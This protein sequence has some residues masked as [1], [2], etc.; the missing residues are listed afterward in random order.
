MDTDLQARI[1][2]LYE[3]ESLTDNLTDA[4]AKILLR[5]AEAQLRE[6]TDETLVVAALQ[7]ANQSDATASDALLAQAQTFLT[8]E[9]QAR[10]IPAARPATAA[11][12]AR[13]QT[14]S[15]APA[16][17]PTLTVSGTVGTASV[18]DA[19]LHAQA[20]EAKSPAKKS[21]RAAKPKAKK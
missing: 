6:N 2:R 21:R 4:N 11:D 13:E 20:G 14:E 18:S 3:N 9:L 12:A 1:E 10:A 15:A 19:R 5:W 8:Q 17:P 16:A 7:T